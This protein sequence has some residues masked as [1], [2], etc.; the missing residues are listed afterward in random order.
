MFDGRVVYCSADRKTGYEAEATA[1]NAKFEA[2]K[3]KVV[4]ARP[5]VTFTEFTGGYPWCANSRKFTFPGTQ[6]GR[7]VRDTEDSLELSWYVAQGDKATWDYF[8]AE[9]SAACP[10]SSNEPVDSFSQQI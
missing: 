7:S 6:F 2:F 4:A 9:Q 8:I 1:R 3:E 5:G 10:S